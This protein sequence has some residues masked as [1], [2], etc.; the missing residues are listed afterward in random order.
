MNGTPIQLDLVEQLATRCIEDV[1]EALGFELDYTIETLPVLDHFCG[2]VRSGPS[3]PEQA[4]G[5]ALM[6]GAYFGEVIRKQH[7]CRWHLSPEGGHSWRL[8][9]EQYYLSFNPIGMA[10]ELLLEGDALGWNA[11]FLTWEDAT[12]ALQARLSRLP[13]VAE[14]DY[15]T[16]SVRN[17]VLETVTDF[18][19]GWTA[20]DPPKVYDAKFYEEQIAAQ[21]EPEVIIDVH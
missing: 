14:G 15:Y 2:R 19:A 16:L 20:K 3:W 17:E 4:Q 13:E 9:F 21:P 6:I 8:D 10:L 5:F 7:A 11:R 1:K 12:E 18:L